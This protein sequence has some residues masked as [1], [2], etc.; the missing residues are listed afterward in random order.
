M[1]KHI[2]V[3][4]LM[5]RSSIYKILPLLAAMAILQIGVKTSPAIPGN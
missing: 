1:K 3:L 2:S 4:C 5:A